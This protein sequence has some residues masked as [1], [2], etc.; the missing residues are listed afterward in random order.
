[1]PPSEQD[2]TG[3]WTSQS[4]GARRFDHSKMR[5]CLRFGDLPA[6]PPWPAL[7]GETSSVAD[8]GRPVPQA[9]LLAF[10]R[11][12]EQ[13][14]PEQPASAWSLRSWQAF[15]PQHAEYVAS[16]P[17]PIDRAAVLWGSRSRCGPVA[18]ADGRVRGCG[19]IVSRVRCGCC[20]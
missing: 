5:R 2:L 20:I 13:G 17:N 19:M 7:V 8:G 9:L 11:W 10:A 3:Q 1:M 14:R 6:R 16:L 12:D 4:S 18:W 15:L